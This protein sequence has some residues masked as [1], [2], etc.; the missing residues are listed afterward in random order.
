MFGFSVLFRPN[1]G[2]KF[3]RSPSTTGGLSVA[4]HCILMFSVE[5]LQP[6]IHVSDATRY[7]RQK[8]LRLRS[9]LGEPAEKFFLRGSQFSDLAP[10]IR[11]LRAL[12]GLDVVKE[13]DQAANFFR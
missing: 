8:R 1:I 13:I 11:D 6:S 2:E 5:A 10:E 12:G 4:S 3:S 9:R 7:Q